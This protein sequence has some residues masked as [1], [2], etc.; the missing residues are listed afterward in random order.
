MIIWG[1]FSDPEA[2]W[3]Q[4]QRQ[5][6]SK[7]GQLDS[8]QH[9]QRA[10]ST[11]G[12]TRRSGQGSEMIVWGGTDQTIYLNTAANIIQAQTVGCPPASR[13]Y[14]LAE[15]LTAPYEA[16]VKWLCGAAW[17]RRS[18]I[19]DT[20]GRYDPADDSWTPIRAQSTPPLHVT[21]TPPCGL[22][23]K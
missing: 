13:T 22:A 4:H 10:L 14:R 20:G 15:S 16:A 11:D 5:I 23:A 19:A 8:N 1:R 21:L 6:Q 9:G 7:R 12:I 2:N 18:T 17:I 3:V